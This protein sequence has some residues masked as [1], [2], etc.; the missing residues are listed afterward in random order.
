MIAS[1]AAIGP[2][3]AS[4]QN[5]AP[6]SGAILDLNGQASPLGAPQLYS[7]TFTAPQTNDSAITFAFRDDPWF[8]QFY[9]VSL[10]DTT[11]GSRNL[12]SNGDFSQGVNFGSQ[13][14]LGWTYN[15]LDGVAYSGWV[16]NSCVG[17]GGS[18]CTYYWNDGAVQGYNELSQ[19]VATTGGDVY[20]LS[21]TATDP[22]GPTFWSRVSTNGNVTDAAGNGADILAYVGGIDGPYGG[23]APELSTWVMMLAGFLG[24]GVARY[25]RAWRTPCV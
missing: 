22:G 7:V 19:S 24:I 14:P 1:L 9:G 18:G 5:F 21:F 11:M 8:T 10:V 20:T 15:N 3:P 13:I 25:R 4:A 23:G 12:L 6:P 16:T 17:P 2:S